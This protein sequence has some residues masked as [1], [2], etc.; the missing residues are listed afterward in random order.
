MQYPVGWP[1]WR[2]MCTKLKFTPAIFIH[3]YKDKDSDNYF[4]SVPSIVGMVKM[5]KNKEEAIKETEIEAAR[6]LF[7]D[8][9]VFVYTSNNCDEYKKEF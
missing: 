3:I 5:S 2:F 7:L 4:V 8:L 1:F 6:R 9:D